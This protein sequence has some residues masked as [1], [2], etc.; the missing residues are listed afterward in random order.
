MSFIPKDV[1]LLPE[2]TS[3]SPDRWV[4]LNVF[5]HSCLGI[6]GEVVQ[7][8][9]RLAEEPFK[10]DNY[11]L[12]WDIER[13]SNEDGLLADPSRF[14]RDTTAWTGLWLDGNSLLEKLKK[15]CIVVDD[16][17]AYRARFQPKRNLLDYLNFGNFHQQH[18]QHLAVEKRA[19]PA[20]W[21]M[22]QKFTADNM[23]VR[24][25][26]LYDAVQWKFMEEFAARRINVGLEVIDLGCGTGVYCNLFAKHGASVLGVDPSEEYLLVARNNAAV[27]TRFVSLKIGQAGGLDAIP[28]ASADMIFMSDALLFYFVPFY[29]TQHAEIQIL[30]ADIRRILKP[31][32]VFIS[33]EPHAV[34]YLTPWLGAADRPFTVV[35]EYLH[36]NFGVVPPLSK[37]IS[38]L[39]QAGFAVTAMQELSPHD[40]FKDVDL[41]G[42][43]FS[44]EF[45]LWQ[46]IELRTLAS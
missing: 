42:Y 44:S 18:G 13:F 30:L 34:F 35:T 19:N 2:S 6:T 38:A 14:I 5:S 24:P 37:M 28:T 27:G 26:T 1:I 20:A 22:R 12:C 10:E 29:P 45:P 41:R 7:A 16:E 32:G 39:T 9:G 25:E 43:C 40:Y 46:L 31:G 11:F 36:K 33:L 15:H 8:L 3:A 23:A 4:A 21:W 17:A